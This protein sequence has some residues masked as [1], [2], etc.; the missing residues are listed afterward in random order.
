MP[1]ARSHAE[2]T[3]ALAS[4]M[5]MFPSGAEADEVE[6]VGHAGRLIEVVDAPDQSALRIRPGAE[7]LDMNVADRQYL[8]RIREFRT[9]RRHRLGEAPIRRAQERKGVQTHLLVLAA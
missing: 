9:D 6:G 3:I 8:R 1:A 5:T 7:V 2:G 4:R